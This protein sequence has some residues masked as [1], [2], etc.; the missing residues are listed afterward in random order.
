[1]ARG[2]LVLENGTVFEGETFGG[3]GEV[4][5]EIVF[6]TGMG[7]YLET[8]TDVSCYGQIVLQTFP[9]VGNYGVIPSDFESPFAGAAAYIVKS[10]CQE[11]SNFR[12]EGNLDTFLK[13][14]NIIGLCNID[15]RALT[16]IIREYGTMN[17]KITTEDPKNINL[18]AIKNYKAAIAVPL[19]SCKKPEFF[20]EQSSACTVAIIDLGLKENLKRELIKRGVGV[21]VIP[22][23]STAQDIKDVK[24]DAVLISNG[25]GDPLGLPEVIHNLKDIIKLGLPI[26]GVCLGHLLLALAH[27]GQIEKMKYGHRGGNQP[28]IEPSTGKIYITSQNHGFAVQ[29]LDPCVAEEWFINVNDNTCEGLIYKN[30]PIFSVQ[31][32]PE[33]CAGPQ[34]TLWLFDKF[35]GDI[36]F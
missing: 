27:G 36:I 23:N 28:V 9:L 8:L 22:Y 3:A 11:P 12:S 4:I 21:W 14:K 2:Y 7:G 13:E 33:G 30:S 1:M 24:A 35:V 26:F 29:K 31:F 32:Q 25:P 16:K 15:T 19:V 18:D 34:D 5:G 6:T 10:W 17:G 20:G